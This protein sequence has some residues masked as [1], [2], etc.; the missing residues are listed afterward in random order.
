MTGSSHLSTGPAGIP[1]HGGGTSE[2]FGD[3]PFFDFRVV[4]DVLDVFDS[5]EELDD[6]DDFDECDEIEELDKPDE[7]DELDMFDEHD[8]CDEHEEC[9][10]PEELEE[11]ELEQVLTLR[12][13]ELLE[14]LL[15]PVGLVEHGADD[16]P[17]GIMGC[18]RDQVLLNSGDLKG[19]VMY[20][21]CDSLCGIS[22][23]RGRDLTPPQRFSPPK[24]EYAVLGECGTAPK[25]DDV[26]LEGA[27]RDS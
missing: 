10:E 2:G 25:M 11:L 12:P 9:E 21:G 14:Q 6:F 15:G 22:K 17:G 18:A 8:D 16:K 7:Q 4:P 23:G 1:V 20:V 27:Y 19:G 5:F 24:V 3:V 26:G 13:P